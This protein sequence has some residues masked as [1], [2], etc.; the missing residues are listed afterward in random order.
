MNKDIHSIIRCLNNLLNNCK[1][2]ILITKLLI[3][4]RKVININILNIR[5][6]LW[7]QIRRCIHSISMSENLT[8]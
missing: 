4:F 8:N 6:L 7:K 3:K 2:K 1:D 5:M